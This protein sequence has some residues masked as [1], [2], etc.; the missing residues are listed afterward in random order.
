MYNALA[1]HRRGASDKGL[2]LVGLT[3]RK[4]DNIT[5]LKGNGKLLA[6]GGPRN[7]ETDD[8]DNFFSRAQK[9]TA[10]WKGLW[11]PSAAPSSN[12]LQGRHVDNFN[13][14]A[15]WISIWFAKK[16]YK[17]RNVARI[18]VHLPNRCRGCRGRE[19]CVEWR[20]FI[21]TR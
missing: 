9:R 3:G 18:C 10:D 11:C 19:E 8:E 6:L 16:D 20:D 7:Y 12:R 21:S 4:R 2:G 15:L 17:F 1:L 13:Q 5:A 14:L